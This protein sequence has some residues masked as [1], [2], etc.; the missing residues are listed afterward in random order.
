MLECLS[1][2]QRAGD[3]CHALWIA[4]FHQATPVIKVAQDQPGDAKT[5]VNI[6]TSLIRGRDSIL[7]HI[8]SKVVPEKVERVGMLEVYVLGRDP[9]EGVKT[10]VQQVAHISPPVGGVDGNADQV[11]FVARG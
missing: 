8:P 6:V 2:R 9:L 1:D 4:K 7:F 3:L 10:P 11:M 5:G